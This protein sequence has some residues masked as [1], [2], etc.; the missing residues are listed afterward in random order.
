MKN[1]WAPSNLD[2]SGEIFETLHSGLKVK[3][4]ATP[5]SDFR[6]C[7]ANEHVS[8]V[9]RRNIDSY[10]FI[11]VVSDGAGGSQHIIGLFH[12]ANYTDHEGIGDR[13]QDHFNS[14]SEDFI[15]GADAS[16]LDFIKDA[17][18]KPCRLVVSGS[19]II[20][21]VSLSD[22]QKL[23]VRAVLFALITGF[24]ITM[25]EAI[26]RTYK[27]ETHWMNSLSLER[28]QNVEYQKSKSEEADA[29]V[30]TLLFTQFADKKTLVKKQ[31]P[32]TRPK[33]SFEKA[34]RTI[35]SLRNKIA[36]AN[37]YANTPTHAR[38]VCKTVRE[39][40]QFRLEIA[41]LQPNIQAPKP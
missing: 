33:K 29:I 10:D 17:D 30:D 23:P 18:A 20:G 21:L 9:L 6:T 19:N 8:A 37:E 4:I 36:H 11:P 13:I 22:L 2:G 5:R 27:S 7:H 12:A 16:I 3:L 1:S 28:R 15:I 39:L 24:E 26:K 41:G 35:E 14:L 31:L 25:M 38:S 32:K 34:L 40:L